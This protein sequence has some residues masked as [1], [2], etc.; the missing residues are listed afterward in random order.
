MKQTL[1]QKVFETNSSSE[2]S[3]CISNGLQWRISDILDEIKSKILDAD[4]KDDLYNAL[5]KLDKV[6]QMILNAVEEA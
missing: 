5:G 6:R 2:H 4:D 1:R 3:L